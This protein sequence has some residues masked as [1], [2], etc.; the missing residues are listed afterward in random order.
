MGQKSQAP[1]PCVDFQMN[2]RKSIA[3]SHSFLEAQKFMRRKNSQSNA[4]NNDVSIADYF[5][6]NPDP[7]Q[8]TIVDC[9]SLL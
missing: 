3:F 5:A 1:H 9:E 8:P 2:K 4:P 7:L 6:N